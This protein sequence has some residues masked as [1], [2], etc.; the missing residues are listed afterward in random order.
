M[1]GV[2][3]AHKGSHELLQPM[4]QGRKQPHNALA[5]FRTDFL[6]SRGVIFLG[7]GKP[8]ARPPTNAPPVLCE[9]GLVAGR[10]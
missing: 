10:L 8:Q 3:D 5:R 4:R 7:G 6:Q 2:G 1:G 9:A